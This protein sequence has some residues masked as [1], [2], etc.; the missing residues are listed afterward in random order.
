MGIV[1]V[2]SREMLSN[3]LLK[4]FNRYVASFKMPTANQNTGPMSDEVRKI[5]SEGR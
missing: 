5:L 1:P 3:R 2:D 4:E